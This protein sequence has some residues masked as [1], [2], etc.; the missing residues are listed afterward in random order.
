M[1]EDAITVTHISDGPEVP[2]C[3]NL[4]PGFRVIMRSEMYPLEAKH[5]DGYISLMQCGFEIGVWYFAV[6]DSLFGPTKTHLVDLPALFKILLKELE[7]V[8]VHGVSLGDVFIR[9]RL[10]PHLAPNGENFI[11]LISA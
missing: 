4:L 2:H 3:F 11:P 9:G 10:A 8:M 6:V 7:P 1:L 5:A